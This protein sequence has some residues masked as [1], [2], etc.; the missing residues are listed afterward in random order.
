MGENLS[1]LGMAAAAVDPRHQRA[2]P[3]GLREP[4]RRSAFGKPAIIDELDIKAADGGRF[5]EHV[6]L[7][8]QAVSQ[9]GCRLIV[10]SS[11]KISRPRLPAFAAGPSAFT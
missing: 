1:D 5:T 6:G 11:A 8:T 10:A 3:L 2:E 4:R 9:V 7:Q